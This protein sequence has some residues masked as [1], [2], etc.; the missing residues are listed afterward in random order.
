MRRRPR[1]TPRVI[2]PLLLAAGCVDGSGDDETIAEDDTSD[3]SSEDSD[4]SDTSGGQGGPCEALGSEIPG[5]SIPPPGD[6]IPLPTCSEG[7]VSDAPLRE[8]DWVVTLGEGYGY[9]A[10]IHA[11]NEGRTLLV[12]SLE[13]RWFDGA[14]TKTAE[15]GHGLDGVGLHAVHVRDSDE[16]V[17]LA[18]GDG[19]DI[20]L[21]E[22]DESGM[23]GEA[24]VVTPGEFPQVLGLFASGADWLIV[25]EEFDATE[26]QQE[27]FFIQADALGAELLRKARPLPGVPGYYGYY[28]GYQPLRYAAFDGANLLFGP[29]GTQWLV[30]AA[31]GT[32]I[33]PSVTLPGISDVIGLAGGGFASTGLQSNATFDG[34]L[35]K[36][37]PAGSTQ[38]T[39]TYDRA[40]TFDQ[41]IQTAALPDGGMVSVGIAGLWYPVD[42][43][44]QPLVIGVDAD[45]NAEWFGLLAGMGAAVRVDVAPDGG[46]AVLGSVEDGTNTDAWIARW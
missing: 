29:S 37:G 13:L 6:D 36:L 8:P 11:L 43:Q 22:F 35:A 19:N 41:L 24:T 34:L 5:F 1:P 46:I 16:H 28:Y 15:H 31:S 12:D 21:L 4:T 44:Q 39:Q 18:A 26:N 32:V 45:G 27:A 40:L 17:F 33:N 10:T 25:G 23:V 30:D 2:A 9:G 3:S 20:R 14:G 42:I 38:W 7:W